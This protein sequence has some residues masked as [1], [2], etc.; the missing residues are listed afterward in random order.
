MSAELQRHP[1]P[2]LSSGAR[3]GR[4]PLQ[5]TMPLA[6]EIKGDREGWAEDSQGP[7][8]SQAA[9]GLLAKPISRKEAPEVR[10]GF[11]S[12]PWG[13]PSLQNQKLHE[14]GA[15]PGPSLENWTDWHGGLPVTP[16]S[17][18]PQMSS[19]HRQ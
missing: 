2:G 14:H 12:G 3:S 11:L 15:Q 19:S 9:L 8:H 4:F 6:R 18:E 5:D 17:Q 13:P 1:K 16:H 10:P 7:S